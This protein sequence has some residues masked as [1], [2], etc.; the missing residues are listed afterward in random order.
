VTAGLA[1]CLLACAALLGS[2][3]GAGAVRLRVRRLAPGRQRGSSVR[4]LAAPG[5]VPGVAGLRWGTWA[6]GFGLCWWVAGPASAVAAAS[7]LVGVVWW[8]AV[9]ASGRLQRTRRVL[10]RAVPESAD[11]LAGCLAAG[12]P[13][14]EA[15]ELVAA[16]AGGPLAPALRRVAA[17][18]RAGAGPG[19]VWVPGGAED[20][21]DPLL[22]AIARTAA[23]GAGLA[24]TVAAVA[25]EARREAAARAEAAARRAGV[26]AVGPLVTCFLPAFVLLGV[27]PVVVGVAEQVLGG[28]R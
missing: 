25:D 11:L 2:R 17:A 19:E 10:E 14:S 23:T 8:P 7:A 1:G 12:A 22:R 16:A 24:D 18:V 3:D 27:V 4:P 6:V 20:V 9:R 15:L 5:P 28:L 21:L 26:L 13:P